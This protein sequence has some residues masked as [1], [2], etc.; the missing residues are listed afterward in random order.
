MVVEGV[1]LLELGSRFLSQTCLFFRACFSSV[2]NAIT[3]RLISHIFYV[4]SF[5][6]YSPDSNHF[7]ILFELFYKCEWL[8]EEGCTFNSRN[9]CNKMLSFK[10]INM[11]LH[12]TPGIVVTEYLFA[13]GVRDERITYDNVTG[14]Y[15]CEAEGR[16][17]P[18]Y[19]W[20]LVHDNGTR[21]VVTTSAQLNVTQYRQY[22]NVTLDFR[23]LVSNI[24]SSKRYTKAVDIT[25]FITG[26]YWN[27]CVKLIARDCCRISCN[28]EHFS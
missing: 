17:Q 11:I 16:P 20:L 28:F 27:N 15:S 22:G 18:E 19:A 21:E 5:M 8:L 26:W 12:W 25:I 4:Y 10:Q 2:V 3:Y 13:D 1:N 24:V 7:Q 9:L 6:N 23:C 14:V